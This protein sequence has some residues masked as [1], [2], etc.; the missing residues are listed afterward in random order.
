M[1]DLGPGVVG[2]SRQGDGVLGTANYVSSAGVHGEITQPTSPATAVL[3]TTA[4]VGVALD[5]ILG[6]TLGRGPAVRGDIRT[7]G[8]AWAMHASN[9]GTAAALRAEQSNPSATVPAVRASAAGT[10]AGIEATSAKGLG[11]TLAGGRAA[12]RLVPR[13]VPGSPSSGAHS[14]G[15]LVIDSAGDMFVCTAAGTP[16]TWRKVQF[17]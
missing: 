6:R 5:A 15:E 12:M 9:A 14:Q 8:V 3:A 7:G 17:V 13:A 4:G 1:T 10:G 11:A 16:G 2:T